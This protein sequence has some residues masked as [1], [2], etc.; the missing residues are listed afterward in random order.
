VW[1]ATSTFVEC[2]LPYLYT[3]W[4]LQH[5]LQPWF[6]EVSRDGA[7]EV[8]QRTFSDAILRASAVVTPNRA[9]AAQL[10]RA[11]P[12]PDDRVLQLPH[13]TPAFALSP[14]SAPR[15]A[16]LAKHAIKR[17]FLF[18]PAQFW[19]HKDHVT[20]VEALG[21]LRDTGLDFSL[22]FC[23]SDRGNARFV[24]QRAADLGVLQHVHFLGFVSMEELCALYQEAFALLYVSLFGP[25]NLPPLEAFGLGCP[26]IAAKVPGAEEQLGDAA[27]LV[28]PMNPQD[29]ASA[30]VR[31]H[32]QAGL[33]D[34]LIARGRAR[35]ARFQ[36]E[37]YVKGILAYL[38]RFDHIR[39]RWSAP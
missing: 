37:D 39:Q 10:Q 18:Y 24:R 30:V 8:R 16:P 19:A 22:V 5:V 28:E 14:R 13:P 34:S 9:G 11:F 31:L 17:P 4:D 23:G 7:W 12:I 38:D 15:D 26:V 25:E 2:G 36:E 29:C 32:A 21:R 1:F 33:R 35:A 27:L 3:V 20:A 6:P